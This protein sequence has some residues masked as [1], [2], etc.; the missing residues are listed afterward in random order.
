MQQQ[1]TDLTTVAPCISG[2]LQ[3]GG[4]A[5]SVKP[6]SCDEQLSSAGVRPFLLCPVPCRDIEAVLAELQHRLCQIIEFHRKL[7]VDRSN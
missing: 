4:S 7:R 1:M 5:D 2:R 3:P 6:Q